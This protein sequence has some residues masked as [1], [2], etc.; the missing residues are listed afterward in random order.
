ML[1]SGRLL[2]S[3]K[4]L[5]VDMKPGSQILCADGS[6]VM[7]VLSTDPKAGTVRVKCLN[8]A[9]LGYAFVTAFRALM[10][11]MHSASAALKADTGCE[12]WEKL[13]ALQL[14]R[15]GSRPLR[16][17]SVPFSKFASSLA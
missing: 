9:T 11:P 5:P 17:P 15:L 8:N 14:C 13:A 2:R 1:N 7:E 16:L 6:I 12:A 10:K 4:K 3:Y